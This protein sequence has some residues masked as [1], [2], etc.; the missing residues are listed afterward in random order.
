MGL[1]SS[2]IGHRVSPGRRSG[3]TLPGRP[4]TQ[5]R[6]G[7]G[8]ALLLG[9]TAQLLWLLCCLWSYIVIAQ[10]FGYEGFVIVAPVGAMRLL[11]IVLTLIGLSFLLPRRLTSPADYVVVALFDISFVPFCV[12]WAL[13]NQPWWQWVMVMA[14][15]GIVLLVDR[16]PLRPTVQYVKGAQNAMLLVASGLVVLGGLLIVAGGHLTLRLALDDVYAVRTVWAT[17]GSGMTMYLFPWLANVLLPL[18]LAHAWKNRRLGELLVLG[19]TAYILFTST[20]MKAYLFMPALVAVVLLVAEWQP[21][22]S[23]MPIGLGVFASAMILLDNITKTI[24]WSSLGLRRVLFVPAQL[25]SVYLDFF[26]VNPVVRMSD[27][28]LLRGWLTYPYPVSVPHLIGAVLGQPAMNAN[29]GL[30]SDGFANFGIVGVL[31]WAVLLGLLLKLLHAATE[32]RENRPEAWAVAAMW[33]VILISSAL[34]TSLLTQGLAL[35]LLAAW[36]LRPNRRS[37]PFYQTSGQVPAAIGL[38]DGAISNRHGLQFASSLKPTSVRE[39]YG[40]RSGEQVRAHDADTW[41]ESRGLLKR[42]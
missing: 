29:N 10:T 8:R 17:E 21:S 32:R 20:G 30:I 2:T 28:I 13:S 11:V 18:L 23:V 31:V 22:S 15:W 41:Q 40:H 7:S 33:P 12:Y 37:Q 9:L 38:A 14:Y 42:G 5:R 3:L 34:T 35:G 24:I 39:S 16:V 25:T 4:A 27:S 6:P 1:S 36:S 19:F 26:A